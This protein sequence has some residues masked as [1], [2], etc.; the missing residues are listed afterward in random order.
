MDLI[1]IMDARSE[2]MDIKKQINTDKI[3]PDGLQQLI[4]QLSD[5]EGN[6]A[7]QRFKDYCDQKCINRKIVVQGF[8]LGPKAAEEIA[9]ILAIN[10]NVAHLDLRKNNLGDTG[11][12]LLM[13]TLKLNN[14]LV[15]LDLG[16]NKI[17]T[18]GSKRVFKDLVS[19]ESLISLRIGNIEND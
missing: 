18:K 16:Q 15:H 2:D 17:T 10:Q 14:S 7:I 11:A 3:T 12:S 8:S 4:Q 1:R 13:N 9:N 6:G 5:G 19:N